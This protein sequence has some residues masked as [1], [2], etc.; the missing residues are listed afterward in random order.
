MKLR[1]IIT[2]M[3]D[4]I[5]PQPRAR[6]PSKSISGDFTTTIAGIP[7]QIVVTHAHKQPASSSSRHKVDSDWDYY[8]YPE[9]EFEVY[10]RKGYPAPW[11]Q[12]KMT[13]QD[14]ERIERE[15]WEQKDNNDPY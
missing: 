7:C 1:D 8:G 9:F 14:E 6:R 3:S 2:E 4:N 13:P 15:Y 5:V 11:L 12:N 10:D